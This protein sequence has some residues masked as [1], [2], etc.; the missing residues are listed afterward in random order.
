LG[1]SGSVSCAP[2]W[3]IR[4]VYC[5]NDHIRSRNDGTLNLTL[6]TRTISVQSTPPTMIS[7]EVPKADS[8]QQRALVVLRQF[9]WNVTS[10]QIL[11]PE[12]SYWFDGD[13]VC[14][15]Y[16]DTGRAWVVA[17]APV[18]S[19]GHLA[20]VTHDF[21]LAAQRRGRRVQ[22]FATEL[23]FL[24]FV[25]FEAVA[26]GEQPTWDPAD[27]SSTVA[28]SRSLRGQ[29]QRARNRGVV[30]RSVEPREIEAPNAPLRLVIESLI[31]C[32]M[33]EKPLPPMGFL[34]HVDPFL[35]A[36]ESRSFVAT[37]DGEVVGF[38]GM[39]PV[40]ARNGWFV[41]HLIRASHAPNGTVEL[42]VDAAMRDAAALGSHYLTLG[43]S[44]LAGAVEFWS[45]TARK[46]GSALYD[47][48]GLQAFKAKFRP[49]EWVPIYL[50]FPPGGTAILAIYD[51]LVA[52]A[53]GRLVR[54]GIEAFLRGPDIVVRLLAIMLIPW[55][56]LL[57]QVNSE[58]WFIA[59]W[60]K[61]FWVLFDVLLC[62]ALFAL[63]TRFKRQLAG[64]VL[65]LVLFDALATIAQALFIDLSRITG[66]AEAAILLVAICAPIVA[67]V[68]LF[69][70]RQRVLRTS[71]TPFIARNPSA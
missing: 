28:A 54:F 71:H 15:A 22:F 53:L 26:I 70:L 30:I 23:R 43:L 20:R 59:P 27:W 52:F 12:F 36:S 37:L 64:P 66:L 32:W 38:A 29:L 55:T 5:S 25:G 13:D 1:P 24:D 2:C 69:N 51:S 11:G 40:Y 50:A 4:F 68:V 34:V 60:L 48:A 17:G 65:G 67:C 31:A 19:E 35:F 44:P 33:G 57:S 41:E 63:S 62:G 56:I 58:R 3:R 39:V 47:F 18:A 45:S 21:C 46:Y 16:L 10:F 9:G 14:I 8:A 6:A 49:R 42:L 7:S 61:W